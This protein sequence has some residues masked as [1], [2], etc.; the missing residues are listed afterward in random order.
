MTGAIWKKA[1]RYLTAAAVCLAVPNTGWAQSGQSYPELRPFARDGALPVI[2]PASNQI[3]AMNELFGNNKGA[4]LFKLPPGGQPPQYFLI[5]DGPMR[6]K[7]LP[8]WKHLNNKGMPTTI[9]RGTGQTPWRA[10]LSTIGEA[11]AARN[12]MIQ[13]CRANRWLFQR[14]PKITVIDLG[15][16]PA[17]APPSSAYV[18]WTQMERVDARAR[19]MR[20][21]GPLQPYIDRMKMRRSFRMSPQTVHTPPTGQLKT[22]PGMSPYL[23]AAI[24]WQMG[25]AIIDEVGE[26]NLNDQGQVFA[27]IYKNLPTPWNITNAGGANMLKGLGET[28]QNTGKELEDI[29]FRSQGLP[30]YYVNGKQEAWLEGIRKRVLKRPCSC[31]GWYNNLTEKL[32]NKQCSHTCDEYYN[33]DYWYE[34]CAPMRPGAATNPCTGGQAG[35]A[36]D[37]P[38]EAS[39]PQGDSAGQACGCDAG[40][41]GLAGWLAPLLLLIVLPRRRR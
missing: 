1:L 36:V 13:N 34:G 10:D 25:V 27:G 29:I 2:N 19:G 6:H 35:G 22:T 38:Y 24:Y 26:E 31:D 16:R 15:S 33:P 5:G 20:V 4:N 12:S 41:A 39:T 18:D 14:Y 30:D 8:L 21:R 32:G 37:P 40:V 7:H 3:H 23:M 11:E 9:Y 28:A 17:G